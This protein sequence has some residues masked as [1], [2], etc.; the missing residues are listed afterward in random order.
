M[1][2]S[3]HL[4]K[5][6]FKIYPQL[7]LESC[8]FLYILFLIIITH[9]ATIPAVI[10]AFLTLPFFIVIP[11]MFGRG[12]VRLLKYINEHFYT[13]ISHFSI[14]FYLFSWL[15]GS[16]IIVTLA[17][18]FTLLHL[19]ILVKILPFLVVAV[20]GL[21][22]LYNL[23][24]NCN[25]KDTKSYSNSLKSFPK[26]NIKVYLALIIAVMLGL[27][28]VFI[29]KMFQPFPYSISTHTWMDP[30]ISVQ[31]AYRAVESGYF[32]PMHRWPDILFPT[33]A[34]SLFNVE[35]LYFLWSA[36]FILTMIYASGIFILCYKL[37][38]KLE[39]AVLG[40]LFGTSINCYEGW[41]G[42]FIVHFK[43]NQILYA[44]FPFVLCSI[45]DIIKD[46]HQIKNLFKSAFSL[47]SIL[48]TTFFAVERLRILE[49]S[50]EWDLFFKSIINPVL[51]IIIPF[52]AFVFS[53]F[54]KKWIYQEFFILVFLS[55]SFFFFM[56]EA[57]TLLYLIVILIFVIS[58][59]YLWKVK[60]RRIIAMTFTLFVF[61]FIY[62]QWINLMV[63]PFRSIFSG[64]F[65][66]T[67]VDIG[68]SSPV[69]EL[70][71]KGF[72]FANGGVIYLLILGGVF[73]LTSP[74]K[75]D[76][77][78]IFMLSA[79]LLIFFLPDISLIRGYKQFSPFM[80]YVL[81]IAVYSIYHK[82]RFPIDTKGKNKRKLTKSMSVILTALILISIL[83]PLYQPHFKSARSWASHQV[84]TK[85]EYDAAFWI[86]KNLPEATI[87]V[88]DYRTMLFLNSLGNKIWITGK[89]MY[90]TW[91]SHSSSKE[92][93]EIIKYK[94]LK[95]YNSE[96]AYANIYRL[97]TLIHPEELQYMRYAGI[98][99]KDITVIV[100]ISSR[101]V[102][103]IE[104]KGIN[105]IMDAQYSKVNP[106]YIKIFN[107]TMY[108]ELLYKI[109]NNLYIFKVKH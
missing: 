46:N 39:I 6:K 12:A 20:I 21:N 107:N 10:M 7:V 60:S 42:Q 17:K 90:G 14:S 5:C 61:I 104:Q 8:A 109:D 34:Y 37:S 105:D 95:G 88:S 35:P 71:K 97:L 3:N 57:E 48:I 80:A 53:S 106:K 41:P 96:E 92:A 66:P 29:L 82:F 16:H 101:T 59:G 67:Y 11:I 78:M 49:S 45:F 100:V 36:P 77:F 27:I 68:P 85:Y 2:Y 94:I 31:P 18:I 9:F 98:D 19:P 62:L 65:N 15:I 81:S 86:K 76:I 44:I 55:M 70:K 91:L 84:I 43:S 1:R 22:L 74:R 32:S 102:K 50:A 28:P 87:V 52:M 64:L 30:V 72:E 26:V 13:F 51:M 63:I 58:W 56:H 23:T 24:C 4:Y 69:F 93:L 75:E 54:L 108:F 33:L 73:A 103:W 38:R 25:N 83:P 79:T 99:P 47:G 40:S 89:R